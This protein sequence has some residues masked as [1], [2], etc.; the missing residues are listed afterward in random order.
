[1]NAVKIII[2]IESTKAGTR[3]FEMCKWITKAT[4]SGRMGHN[5][6]FYRYLVVR[7]FWR[8]RPEAVSVQECEG[9]QPQRESWSGMTKESTQFYV[10]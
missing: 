4:R 1:M 5:P 7:A 3:L 6:T 10:G 8:Y 2:T 9:Q